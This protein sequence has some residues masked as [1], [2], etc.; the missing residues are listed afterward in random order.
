MEK[1]CARCGKCCLKSSPTLQKEDI[2]LIQKG[3]IQSHN[4][5]TIRIGEL[6][7][8]NI[9]AQLK[10]NG[11]ELIKIKEKEGNKGCIF[12][13]EE[14]EACS[15]YINRPAQCSAFVC[16]DDS[17]FMRVY[18]GPKLT[19]KELI[20]DNTL[21]GLIKE[22]EKKCAYNVLDK[23]VRQIEKD[24]ENAVQEI[25]TLLRFDHR[26]RPFVSEKMEVDPAE[27]DF[28]FGRPL[29]ETITMFGLELRKEPDG[30]F[31]LTTS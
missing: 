13:D 18:N 30:S 29:N 11:T 26:L 5:Y 9:N 1:K 23:L 12:Y 10:I 16:W 4:F 19:R 21:L 20:R 28:V 22:H 24:G 31:F 2:G 3:L 14:G 8:D 7:R 27:M 15:I 6:V 17:E 25:L